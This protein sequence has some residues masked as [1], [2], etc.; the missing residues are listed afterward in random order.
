VLSTRDSAKI[1]PYQPQLTAIANDLRATTVARDM[2]GMQR[3][4]LAQKKVFEAAGVDPVQLS[5]VGLSTIVLQLPLSFGMFFGI[6]ALCDFP[7]EHL[8]NSGFSLIPDLTVADPTYMLPLVSAALISFQ[9]K[10]SLFLAS[11]TQCA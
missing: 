8:K 11:S 1:A 5:L 10:V 7:V 6:K 9:T 3:A 2:A 4:R